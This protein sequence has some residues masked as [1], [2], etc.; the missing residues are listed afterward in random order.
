MNKLKPKITLD[1]DIL[2]KINTFYKYKI[3]KSALYTECFSH[4]SL[5]FHTCNPI[6]LLDGGEKCSF[7]NH[8]PGGICKIT[9]HIN[10]YCLAA[11]AF[12][13]GIGGDNF[14]S[15]VIYNLKTKY[16][17][18]YKLVLE[19]IGDNDDNLMDGMAQDLTKVEINSK[20][21]RMP[22]KKN[23]KTKNQTKKQGATKQDV[24]GDLISFSDAAKLYECSYH[25]IYVHVKKGNLEKVKGGD[26]KNYIRKSDV[27]AM[28]EKNKNN[29]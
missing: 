11:F 3:G 28:I 27:M 29:K 8:A 19:K 24:S 15:A 26:G 16:K 9:C 6:A 22:N 20:E 12:R 18:L 5:D 13:L 7:C 14:D 1:K 25:N 17:E 10:H 21:D 23:T 4:P 2:A